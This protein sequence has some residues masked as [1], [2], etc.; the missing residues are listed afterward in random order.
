MIGAFVGRDLKVE[1]SFTNVTTGILHQIR[2]KLCDCAVGQA[3]GRLLLSG[4]NVL[5]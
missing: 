4:S 5:K 2:T 3:G 1:G